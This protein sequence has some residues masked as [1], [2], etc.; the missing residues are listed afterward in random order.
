MREQL[1]SI[2]SKI[3]YPTRAATSSSTVFSNVNPELLHN[4]DSCISGERDRRHEG[5][6]ESDLDIEG[7]QRTSIASTPPLRLLVVDENAQ[8]RNEFCKVA[9][10]LGFLIDE[11]GTTTAAREIL[12]RK[13]T[14][15]L[16]LDVTRPESGAQ[17]LLEE[18]RVLHPETRVIAMSSNGTIAA[19]VNTMR[20]GAHDYLSKPFPLHVLT[21]SLERAAKRQYFDLARRELQEKSHPGAGSFGVLGQSPEM[22]SLYSILSKVADKKH[23]VMI[24]GEN[25]TGKPLVARA[26]HENGPDA[27]KPFVSLDCKRLGPALLEIEL[28]GHVKGAFRETDP[29]KRG[30]LASPQGGTLFLDQIGDLPPELQ[31]RLLTALKDKEVRP[32]GGIKALPISVRILAATN[33]DLIKMMR[34][35]RFRLDLYRLLSVVNLRIPPLRGRPEDIALLAKQFLEK[36]PHQN[37]IKRTLSDETLR[38]LQTYDW[39]DN[40]RE[41]K[42]SIVRACSQTD[43]AELQHIHLPQNLINFHRKKD[44]ELPRSVASDTTPTEADI[45]PIAQMEERAILDALRLTGGDKLRAAE[46][47]GI[48]RTTLY[49]KLKEYGLVET[50]KLSSESAAIRSTSVA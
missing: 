8:I 27:S 19:A 28:F 38:M 7:L 26:I 23:P 50:A 36:I 42:Q 31:G 22:E 17:S 14:A 43:G 39:P 44:L 18:M 11:T 24:V 1:S 48:G 33:R 29:E 49:R 34:E 21:A 25:G 45:V 6:D 9:A 32:I 35:G 13:Q 37:G 4:P 20:I 40:V 10:S 41:L 16:L 12:E 5:H 46:L 3:S 30:L 15:I 2:A 47:L